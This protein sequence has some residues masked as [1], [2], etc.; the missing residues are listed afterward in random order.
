[1]RKS[2]EGWRL[3]KSILDEVQQALQYEVC[4]LKVSIQS[5]SK[6]VFPASHKVS[7][8]SPWATSN[9]GEHYGAGNQRRL[10]LSTDF[11]VG[12][13]AERVLLRWVRYGGLPNVMHRTR[14][15][16]V[17][18]M[19]LIDPHPPDRRPPRPPATTSSDRRPFPRPKGC[20]PRI[21]ESGLC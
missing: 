15:E 13:I 17:R 14:R 6:A 19:V 11:S 5:L 2:L 9:A 12:R 20:H 4:F 8:I 18:G 3:T 1:M 7:C 10:G 16:L 21:R